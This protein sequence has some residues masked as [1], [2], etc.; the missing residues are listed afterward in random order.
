MAIAIASLVDS[1]RTRQQGWGE[2][3]WG[4]YWMDP[5]WVMRQAAMVAFDSVEFTLWVE[6]REQLR[7]PERDNKNTWT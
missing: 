4:E 1:Q 3:R 5:I 7:A 2:V 6:P